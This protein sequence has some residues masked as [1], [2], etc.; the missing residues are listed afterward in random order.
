M[1]ACKNCGKEFEKETQLKGHMMTCRKSKEPTTLVTDVY[2]PESD[3]VE[4]EE[5]VKMDK[6]L[7]L[8]PPV[9][10][11]LK[12][13]FGN[14]LNYF[15]VSRTEYKK[16]FG[17]YGVR[18]EIPK[19]FSTE[20]KEEL[21]EKYDN[22]TRKP[23]VDENGVPM[24]FMHVTPDIRYVSLQLEMPRVINML[25][26]IKEHIITNAHSKGVQ[27]PSIGEEVRNDKTL[28]D[29]KRSLYR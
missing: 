4:P 19:Q 29:Y 27:L 26:R 6:Y 1:F 8:P 25:E 24:R 28:E 5:E 18:I 9:I 23:A 17:G 10:D 12:I 13:N 22:I 20:W 16:D 15:P 11:W 21:R 3:V 7:E 14:W 2:T